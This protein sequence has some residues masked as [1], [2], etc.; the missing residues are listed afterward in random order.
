M[1][2]GASAKKVSCSED[3]DDKGFSAA[4]KMTCTFDDCP[5]ILNEW[6]DIGE[7]KCRTCQHGRFYH[8]TIDTMLVDAS[9][10]KMSSNLLSLQGKFGRD[11]TGTDSND[12]RPPIRE[13]KASTDTVPELTDSPRSSSCTVLKHLFSLRCVR[14]T[15]G[16]LRVSSV[17]FP[18]KG[19]IVVARL[20]RGPKA[21][22]SVHRVNTHACTT[23]QPRS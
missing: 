18:T 10:N 13:R 17:S 19:A 4:N 16:G 7:T 5:C 2:C 1:G 21:Q 3:S 23:N 14:I 22:L 15:P 12:T 20:R 9:I 6:H 11:V 8:Q